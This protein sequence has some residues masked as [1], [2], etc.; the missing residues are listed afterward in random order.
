MTRYLL[1]VAIL[2]VPV[3]RVLPGDS[4]RGYELHEVRLRGRTFFQI[5]PNC[6]A[7]TVAI[8]DPYHE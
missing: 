2:V 6:F 8:T 5:N 4:R 3:K 1:A 7:A